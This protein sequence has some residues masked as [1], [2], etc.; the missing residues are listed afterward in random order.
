MGPFNCANWYHSRVIPLE[1]GDSG[2]S[3]ARSQPPTPSPIR[4]RPRGLQPGLHPPN[5][6]PISKCARCPLI[7]LP[8]LLAAAFDPEA[9]R[10]AP[11]LSAGFFR[12]FCHKRTKGP[13]GG[14]VGAGG[15][16]TALNLVIHTHVCSRTY[17]PREQILLFQVFSYQALWV[18]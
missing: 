11:R 9:G 1:S 12:H 16:G 5:R 2:S 17:T 3:W 18:H 4:T 15:E 7:K 14:R 13:N 10:P 6:P 8:A